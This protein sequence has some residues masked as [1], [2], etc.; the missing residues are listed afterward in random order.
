MIWS[1]VPTEVIFGG[2]P[3]PEALQTARY[4]G[5]RVTVRQGRVDR[6]LSTDAADF[7]DP[8]FQPGSPVE[9]AKA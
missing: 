6:L 7:L 8:W 4:L 3:G 2:G 9:Q 1:I 5:R